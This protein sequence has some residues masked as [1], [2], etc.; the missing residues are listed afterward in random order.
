M[1]YNVLY[2][3]ATW[4]RRST[5]V[6]LCTGRSAKNSVCVQCLIIRSVVWMWECNCLRWHLHRIKKRTPY[7]WKETSQQPVLLKKLSRNTS[8]RP[9]IS[10][11]K[12]F[13]LGITV[14]N[15]IVKEFFVKVKN[16]WELHI[17]TIT[18]VFKPQFH[19]AHVVCV[20]ET[21]LKSP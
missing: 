8:L 15:T 20:T 5:T 2:F 18:L 11:A 7:L 13:D 12:V 10:L 3:C 4:T 9:V 17:S 16:T 1:V 19:S 21:T 14:P 6:F